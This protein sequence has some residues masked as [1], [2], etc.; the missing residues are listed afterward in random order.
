MSTRVTVVEDDRA[1]R[2]HLAALIGGAPGF[3]CV[4]APRQR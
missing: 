3:T 4:G 1:F 2:E